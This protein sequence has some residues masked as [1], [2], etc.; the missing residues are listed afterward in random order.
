MDLS[1][2][3]KVGHKTSDFFSSVLLFILIVENI[4]ILDATSSK[5]GAH[6]VVVGNNGIRSGAAGIALNSKIVT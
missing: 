1:I 2:V 5:S 3:M 4:K 6:V